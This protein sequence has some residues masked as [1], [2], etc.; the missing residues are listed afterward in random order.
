MW[1]WIITGF[2]LGGLVLWLVFWLRGRNIM[3]KWYEWL[4]GAIGFLLLVFA[5]QNLFA[6][7]E[8]MEST[9]AGM[10]L[11]VFG[12]PAVILMAV[13]GQLIR[14]RHVAG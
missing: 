6:A 4:I 5:I 13:A 9:A 14:R 7:F 2:V 10:I 3:V 1:I 12:L 8:E 11:L